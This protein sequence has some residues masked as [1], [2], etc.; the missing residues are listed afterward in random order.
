MKR[1]L[2]SLLVCFMLLLMV[3]LC[4]SAAISDED[5]LGTW[6]GSYTITENDKKVTK[7]LSLNI[8]A[9]ESGNFSGT[10]EA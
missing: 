2:V 8:S 7:K 10:V 3:P 1:R 9:I 6:S 4:S 5:I